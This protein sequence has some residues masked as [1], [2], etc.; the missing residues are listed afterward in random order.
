ML[1][2]Y[3]TTLRDGSQMEGISY[4]TED[5][6]RITKALDRLGVDYVEGGWPGSN[7]KDIEYFLKV[8]D[9][10]FKNLKVAAF[11]STRRANIL[12]KDDH[13]LNQI[14]KSQVK[15]ATIFGKTWDMHVKV[16][17][18]TTL[19]EN[20][21]MIESSIAYLKAHGLEV[22]FDA[23][24]FFDGFNSNPAYARKVI[25]AAVKGGADCIVF[26]DTNGGTLPSRVKE[27]VTE[28]K[29][30][31]DCPIGIH[32][33]NDCELAVANSLVAFESGISHIQGTINGFGERCG[34]ANLSSV[35]PNLMIKY[36]EGL[37][38]KIKLRKITEISRFVSEL[39]NTAHPS[40][41]PYVG[42]SAFTHKGG[43]HVSA[44][45]KN[46]MTYEHIKPAQVGNQ[47][48]VVVSELSGQSNI[49]YKAKELGVDLEY[50]QGDL[51]N[52]VKRIK[53]LEHEGYHFEGADGS[54]RILIEKAIGRFKELFQLEGAR[55]ITEK[56]KDEK[57]YSEVSIKVNVK[58]QEVHTAASGNGP[59]NALDQ[60]MRKALIDFYPRLKDF[61][62]VD[63][64]VR[65]LDSN[66]GTEA[67]V[68]VLIE[69][70][71]GH[72]NW[73]TVGASTNIIE[74]SWKALVDSLEYGLA[75]TKNNE[76]EAER[77]IS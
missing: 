19:E 23:E 27:I 74:A 45:L 28:V 7:P 35:I 56:R 31:I 76:S 18:K 66:D 60:A 48:E 69:T 65:V 67:K 63:Y 20:L 68:R 6:I 39:I 33:H 54:L 21:R 9:L 70:S 43:I 37:L 72:E 17:L 8:K 24:H 49:I 50:H 25:E 32:A 13:N 5:K 16:A 71:D 62:L 12:A 1:K 47:R 58:G 34:N 64:K 26:C 75:Y 10:S 52:V 36:D 57:A 2:I 14:I 42:G 38:P 41:L 46:A 40:Q 53:A 4:S 61:Y 22:N 55:I 59:V 51:K 15:V 3:D 30:M 11:G 73:G 44:I 77:Q 29:P